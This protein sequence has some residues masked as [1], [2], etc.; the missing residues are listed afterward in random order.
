M[1]LELE[2]RNSDIRNSWRIFGKAVQLEQL[3]ILL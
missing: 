2:E 1:H 3:E